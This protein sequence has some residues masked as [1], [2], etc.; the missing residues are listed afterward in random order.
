MR[1]IESPLTNC[2][3]GVGGG[4]LCTSFDRETL[5]NKF[6]RHLVVFSFSP[7]VY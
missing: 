2:G 4:V 5:Y 3:K 6:I 1:Y 7:D